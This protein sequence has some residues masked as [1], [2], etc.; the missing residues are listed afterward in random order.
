MPLRKNNNNSTF[1]RKKKEIENVLSHSVIVKATVRQAGDSYTSKRLFQSAKSLSAD[2]RLVQW[3][4]KQHWRVC[5]R[6]STCWVSL[7]IYIYLC[8]S[9][10]V[11][12]FGS[13]L[14]WKH[15]GR[16]DRCFH[17]IYT[18]FWPYH[19][20]VSVETRLIGPGNLFPIFYCSILVSPGKL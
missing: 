9:V 12:V 8:A 14:T 18:K 20:N 11:C 17:V 16:M 1:R 7:Y 19:L 3:A 6:N 10:C 4:E 5:Q 13:I 15:H 2:F